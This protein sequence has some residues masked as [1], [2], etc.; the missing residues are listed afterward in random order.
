MLRHLLSL[1]PWCC[2]HH[3]AQEQ[4]KL[5]SLFSLLSCSLLTSRDVN[6]QPQDS[7]QLIAFSCFMEP[8]LHPEAIPTQERVK[9][10]LQETSDA[11]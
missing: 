9:M 4:N 3:W 1:A 8:K 11:V 10:E 5:L 7:L 2:A 6:T